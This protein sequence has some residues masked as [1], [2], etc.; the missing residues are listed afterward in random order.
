[1]YDY[2]K[3]KGRIVEVCGTHSKF[4]DQ[5]GITKASLSNK[6]NEK[7]YFKQDEIRKAMD[8]LKIENPAPYF[9]EKKL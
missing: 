3:L 2:S 5:M 7:N 1:M 9:F 6:L 4:A 8:I